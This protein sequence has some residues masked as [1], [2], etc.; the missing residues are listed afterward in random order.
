MGNTIDAGLKKE[1][2]LNIFL[3]AFTAHLLPLSV[4]SRDFSPSPVEKG[5]KV[6][7]PYAPLAA[8]AIDFGG[9][10]TTQDTEWKKAEVTIDKHK[11][12]S[13]GLSDKDVFSTPAATLEMQARQ[14]AFQL[15]KAVMLDIFSSITNANF[16]AAVFAGAASGFDLDDVA[17]I[18]GACDDAEMPEDPRGLV[19]ARSY[20]TAV[21]KDNNMQDVSA[22]GTD[23]V[24]R[25]GKLPQI[26][27]FTPYKSTVI[28]ANA[29][30]LVGFAC[31]PSAMGVGMRYLQPQKPE[32]YIDARALTDPE[33]G[34]TIGFRDD[35][36]TKTGVRSQVFECNYGY[37][38]I[39]KA[40]LK[41]LTDAA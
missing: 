37:A 25:M 3:E 31:F 24:L 36:D 35:Y 20:Y 16:G 13:M 27:G 15:A 8:T 41:R 7:V 4:F 32:A 34:I 10:Y 23:Q 17:D 28:P 19:L 33:T 1:T 9:T 11:F 26:H 22:A 14:K 29:E 5:D 38:V 30:K 40:A 39:E 21:V 12:V 6:K 18:A 2:V